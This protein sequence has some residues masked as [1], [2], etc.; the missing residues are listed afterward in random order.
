MPNKGFRPGYVVGHVPDDPKELSKFLKVELQRIA[1]TLE[2]VQQ[3]HLGVTSVAPLKPRDGDIRI[4]DG[5]NWDPVG[6]GAARLAIYTAS[7][8]W[9]PSATLTWRR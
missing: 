8:T 7:G 4:T 3:G 2:M 5:V 1:R 9:S 6:D